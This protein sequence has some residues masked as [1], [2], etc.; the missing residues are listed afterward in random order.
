MAE[1]ERYLPDPI[2]K[3]DALLQQYGLA[4][5]AISVRM[6]GCPNGCSR[7]VLAQIGFIGK[8]P[9]MYNMYLGGGHWEQRFSALY[10]ENINEAEI[11][12]C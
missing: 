5:E 11:L 10:R 12:L 2:S 8:G 3:I 9:G 7:A 4:D 6:Q 1:S